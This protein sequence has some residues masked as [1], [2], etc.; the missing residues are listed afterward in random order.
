[1]RFQ[2][3]RHAARNR[4][5][6]R[7]MKDAI[8]AGY[9]AGHGGSIGQVGF[10]EIDLLANLPQVFQPPGREIIEHAHLQAALDQ[11]IDQMRADETCSA[12]DEDFTHAE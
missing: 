4:G 6:G 5:D 11:R 3:L 8:D 2:R 10:D 12:G 7:L 1:M 9:C